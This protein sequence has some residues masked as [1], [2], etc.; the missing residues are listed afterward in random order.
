M[1]RS[2]MQKDMNQSIQEHKDGSNLKSSEKSVDQL[3]SHLTDL[4]RSSTKDKKSSDE[5]IDSFL[6]SIKKEYGHSVLE[7]A[8]NKLSDIDKNEPILNPENRRFTVFPI[9]YNNIWNEYKKQFACLWKVE[10]IDFS[11][12]YNDFL[13]LTKDEQHFVKM[14]IAF[15]AASDGIVNFNLGE[16]FSR[17]IQI[18]EAQVAYTFQMMMENVH[19]ETYSLMLENIVRDPKEREFMFNAIENVSSIKM[20]ADWAFKWIDSSE[21]FGYR[22][23]AFA[24]VE[25]IFFSGAF[26]SIFWLKK[27][28]N[29]QSGSKQF[30]NGLVQSNKF[31]ARDE[32]LHVLFACEM[33]KLLHNKVKTDD[34]NSMVMEAVGISKHFTIDSLPVRLIGMN[35]DMMCDY[36]EYVADILLSMLGYNKLYNKKNPFG[37]MN[38]IGFTDKTNLH[39]G[40]RPAEYQDA[41]TMNKNKGAKKVVIDDDF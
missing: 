32:G 12:D 33:Y 29:S 24:I 8:S 19:G 1:N 22:I 5:V 21:S 14:I 26:A 36:I 9:K 25:A 39:D 10:E 41:N 16:R 2:S 27:Y 3:V 30:M 15:F 13:T 11:G 17:E 4:L 6:E 28:K 38:T 35:S 18:M 31:I 23:V 7:K 20:M 40:G 34:V 37:F